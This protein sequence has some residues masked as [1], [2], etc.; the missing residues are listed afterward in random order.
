MHIDRTVLWEGSTFYE[1]QIRIERIHDM[2]NSQDT[3]EH[4]VPTLQ[5]LVLKIP[6]NSVLGCRLLRCLASDR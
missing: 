5:R 6:G 4:C 2:D 1:R 3:E